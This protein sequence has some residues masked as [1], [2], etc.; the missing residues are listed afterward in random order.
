MKRIKKQEEIIEIAEALF[1]KHG[2][3]GTSVRDIAQ[4][5]QINVA[6][7]NY[8]FGSKENLL[9]IIVDK[10]VETFKMD[11][12]KFNK[13]EDPLVRLD[14]MIDHYIDIKINNRYL[15]RVM[16]QEAE[17]KKRIINSENFK[18]MRKHNIQLIKELIEYGVAKG[19][20]HYYDPFLIHSTM[21]GTYIHY[22]MNKPLIEE[23]Q[24]IDLSNNEKEFFQETI[25]KHLKLI[26][27]SLLTHENN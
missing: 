20:F 4:E 12:N 26:V 18:I 23:L 3:E 5:A 15:Y 17:L 21:I 25:L 22:R 10:G 16:T 9:E 1:A 7:V 8:Y 6:M 19:V 24:Q 2:F 13:S 11:P 14:K 27:K